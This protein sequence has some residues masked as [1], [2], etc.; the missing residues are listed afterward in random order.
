MQ[1]DIEV[2]ENLR[3]KSDNLPLFF[4]N[5]SVRKNDFGEQNNCRVL[6]SLLRI[7][8]NVGAVI[9]LLHHFLLYKQVRSVANEHSFAVSC[10]YLENN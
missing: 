6:H 3:S 8:V 7:I 10:S 9:Q 2:P 1:C 5:N 4:K